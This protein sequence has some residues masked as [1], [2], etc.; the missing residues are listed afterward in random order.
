MSA[1]P[2][3][4]ATVSLAS[5]LT[6]V[7][8]GPAPASTH[9]P[10]PVRA[11]AQ[12]VTS[13]TSVALSTTRSAYG[14]TITATASVVTSTGRP[15]GAVYFSVDG[16]ATR[17]NLGARTTVTLALPD[18]PVG[19]HAV[20]ASFVPNY[21]DD[22]RGSTS[23]VQPWTV[24]RVRTRLFVTV[25]G[26]GLRIPTSVRVEAGG[27][28]GSAPTGRVTLTL[29]RAGSGRTTTRARA[30]PA[31]GVVVA[32][33]GTLGK[34]RYRSVVTYAGDSQHLPERRVQWFQVRQR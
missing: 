2:R 26:R 12:A 24:E 1:L 15:E 17:A 33:Y 14:Q 32:R 16:V 5:A 29:T 31:D 11:A 18:A 34:G 3:A 23:P 30:L 28:Y 25:Q 13:A 6:V 10:A 21:P 7:G 22:Q 9:G 19:D 27:E 4:L 8:S 20:T